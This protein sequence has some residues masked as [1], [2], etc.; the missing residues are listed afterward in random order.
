KVPTA[1]RTNGA[2]R[3]TFYKTHPYI[4]PNTVSKSKAPICKPFI[5]HTT[6]KPRLSLARVHTANPSAVS[7]AWVKAAR[8][9]AVSATRINAVKSSAVTAVQHNHTKK[10]WK[11]KTLVLDHVFKT[12]SASMTLKRF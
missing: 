7:A 9:S 8:L 3:T 2:A 11:P 4:A 12:T 5:R 10:V 1:A 6:S